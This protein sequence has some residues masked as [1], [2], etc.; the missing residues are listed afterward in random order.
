[1]ITSDE[2]LKN[3]IQ[4]PISLFNMLNTFD[5]YLEVQAYLENGDS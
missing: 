3:R 5:K 2:N 4:S 1:M